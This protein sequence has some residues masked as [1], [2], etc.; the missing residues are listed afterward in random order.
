MNF[1]SELIV[2]E[3]A[4]N[5]MK[6][7]AIEFAHACVMECSRR[8]EFDG[9]E[10]VKL[11]GLRNPVVKTKITKEKRVQNKPKY[12]FPYNGERNMEV[13]QGLILNG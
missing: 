2:N 3:K 5:G 8:Y 4:L 13:C 12:T 10:A 7:V 11:L 6:D 9:E 1:N